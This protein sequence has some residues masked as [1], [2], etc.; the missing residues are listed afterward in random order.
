MCGIILLH[1]PKAEARLPEALRRLRH[2]GPDELWSGHDRGLHFGFARLAIHRGCSQADRQEGQIALINGEIYNHRA[3]KRK[4]GLPP[5]DCDTDVLS[6]LLARIGPEALI[7]ELDGFYSALVLSPD[8]LFAL[9]DPMGKKPLF[10]GRSGSELFITSELKALDE[11]S[12]FEIL[13]RGFSVID[14][15]AAKVQ[16]VSAAKASPAGAARQS[17]VVERF[18]RAVQKRMPPSHQGLGVFLSGG[19][20]SALVAAFASKLRPDIRYFTLGEGEDSGFADKVAEALGIQLEHVKLPEPEELPS[21]IREVVYATE[22]YNPSILSNGLA[23]Y[24]LARAA[25]REGIKVVLSGDGADELFGGYH[26]FDRD[27]PW[28]Q[29][30]AQLI[31][32]MHYTELRRLD[33]S[34]MAHSV[35]PRCPFLDRKLLQLSAGL[36]FEDLYGG[37]TNK[38]IL[39]RAFSDHLPEEIL[40]RAKTS[41]DVG[42]GIRREVIRYLRRGRLSEREALRRIWRER[43]SGFDAAHPYFH[44]YPVFDAAIDGRGPVHR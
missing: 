14:L 6:P 10:F 32:D 1:G 27:D 2:R 7:D 30:R 44:K 34:C 15:Q 29:T 11:A 43:F 37:G 9:R 23:S 36:D 13:P 18:A 22:S 3:L 20:D 8:R 25:H 5:S 33:M 42:S 21:L 41:F 31:E 38:S 35:E 17:A 4:Y 40:Q 39:R 12:C 26:H 24:L 19:L 16:P 28:R